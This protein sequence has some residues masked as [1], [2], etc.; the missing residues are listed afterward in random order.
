MASEYAA[1][2]HDDSSPDAATV[3]VQGG[4]VSNLRGRFWYWYLPWLFRGSARIQVIVPD[5]WYIFAP[6]APHPAY[7]LQQGQLAVERHPLVGQVRPCPLS[8]LYLTLPTVTAGYSSVNSPA[9]IKWRTS[10]RPKRSA[11][12]PLTRTTETEVFAAGKK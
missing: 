1:Q 12:S 5:Q 4:S 9:A 11:R 3:A 7:C 2:I 8:P 10:F 6:F